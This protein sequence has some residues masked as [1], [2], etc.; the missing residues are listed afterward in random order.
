M[1]LLI[2]NQLVVLRLPQDLCQMDLDQ[3]EHPFL[4]KDRQYPAMPHRSTKKSNGISRNIGSHDAG[5]MNGFELYVEGNGAL[6][7]NGDCKSKNMKRRLAEDT[8]A[9]PNS[10]VIFVNYAKER[11]EGFSG[12]GGYGDGDIGEWENN[13]EGRATGAI[14]QRF[15]ISMSNVKEDAEDS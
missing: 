2:A 6:Q 3:G 8:L 9:D 14:E 4:K 15:W 11:T 12:S 13:Q 10:R 1:A 7:L 5:R